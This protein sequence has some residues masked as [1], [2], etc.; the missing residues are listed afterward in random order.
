[1]TFSEKE[2]L[3]VP[4]ILS[5][6]MNQFTPTENDLLKLSSFISNSIN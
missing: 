5:F 2:I 4:V 3:T 1:M 6:V